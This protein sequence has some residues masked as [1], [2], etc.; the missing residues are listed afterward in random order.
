[1]AWTETLRARLLRSRERR[2]RRRLARRLRQAH[3]RFHHWHPARRRLPAV[4]RLAAPDRLRLRILA[5]R[6]LHDKAIVGAGGQAVDDAMRAAIAIQACLPV[7]ALGLEVYRGWQTVLVYPDTF[8]VDRVELDEAG[9]L[10]ESREELAGESWEQGPV[11]LS[12][13]DIERHGPH[14]ELDGAIIIHELSHKLD[15]LNGGPNGMPPLHHDMDP[16]AWTRAFSEAYASLCADLEAGREPDI[17][18]YAAESPGEFFAVLSEAFFEMPVRLRASYP[19][20]YRQLARFYRQDPAAPQPAASS[21]RG[22]RPG[23][24]L[25]S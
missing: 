25:L 8:L 21:A 5:S 16:Q 11:I 22:G 10:H 15:M 6:F 17:D 1:M 7:L 23:C 19:A 13:G 3:L 4:A 20:V 9:V 18:P 2:R 14:G 24:A 12:W